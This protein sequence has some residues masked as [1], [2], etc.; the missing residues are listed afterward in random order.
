M[1]AP[2]TRPHPAG[3]LV[4]AIL[5]IAACDSGGSTGPQQTPQVTG[6]S[7]TGPANSVAIAGTLQLSASISPTGAPTGVTWTTSDALVATVNSAGLVSGVAPGSVT[8]TATSTSNAAMSGSIQLNVTCP[9][10]RM[11]TTNPTGNTTWQNWI[12]SRACFDYV[13]ATDVNMS[14]GVL[15][16]EPGT[17]VAFEPARS[18]RIAGAAGLIAA[19]AA[20]NT[21]VL[22]GTQPG[23]GQWGGV[24]F[25]NS[26]FGGNRI[27]HILINFA[28]VAPWS[29]SVIR[30]NLMVV[31]SST[32]LAG[33]ELEHG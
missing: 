8:I 4:I 31:N 16:I 12:P 6:V 18:M 1:S 28:G 22:T 15:T 10:P 32:T 7:V 2:R 25:D 14:S 17:L 9:A 30:A 13:V 21:I 19:G 23:R 29:S 24:F 33:A 20:Q 11:V 5:G 26:S 27:E 3:L